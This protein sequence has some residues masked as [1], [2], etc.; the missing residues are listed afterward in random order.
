M[1]FGRRAIRDGRLKVYGYLCYYVGQQIVCFC[2]PGVEA[3]TDKMG[4]HFHSMVSSSRDAPPIRS[5]SS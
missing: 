4:I 2:V 1:A 5:L 3:W